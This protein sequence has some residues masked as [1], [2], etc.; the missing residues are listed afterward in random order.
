TTTIGAQRKNNYALQPMAKDVF[1][2]MMGEGLETPPQY[3][4]ID[5][6]INRKG[7][8]NNMETLLT[9][10]VHTID[11]SDFKK[12]I[13]AGTV[14]LDTRTADEFAK[15]HIP[16]AINIGLGGQFAIWVG[17]IFSDVPF[18]LICDEGKESETVM[19]L[20]RVGYDKVLGYLKGGVK[21]W[22]DAGNKTQSI[23]SI[24]A[25]DFV[26]HI[27]DGS[28]LIDVRNEGEVAHGTIKDALNIPLAA[29]PKRLNEL[30]KN[31]HYYVYCQGG[32]RSMIANSI[33]QKNGFTKITN[34]LG[35]MGAIAKTG[36]KLEVHAEV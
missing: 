22:K 6:A 28:T 21:T 33:L 3:F 27:G 12:A 36:I 8:E 20:A 4:F 5:A 14:V 34:V 7:Y 10:N 17:S 13:E 35:G 30:D 9:K 15:E 23:E 32:Y 2:K 19:R 11:I 1:I 26:K 24:S 25:T 31:T 29:L 16:G 18:L